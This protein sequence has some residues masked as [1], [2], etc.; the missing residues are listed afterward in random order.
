MNFDYN[1]NIKLPFYF[2]LVHINDNS[3][4]LMGGKYNC[5]ENSMNDCYKIIIDD[6]NLEIEK[7]DDFKLPK[8]DE[9]NGKM[10]A[11]FGNDYY[12]EFS[13]SSQGSFYLV[14]SKKKT[15]EKIN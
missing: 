7:D 15:I 1:N 13:S 3:F 6:Q 14:N 11:S 5:K 8:K 2:G 10:F 9:F 4:L 12:G